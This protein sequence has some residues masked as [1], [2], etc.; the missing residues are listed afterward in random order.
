[1]IIVNNDAA[2]TK[3]IYLHLRGAIENIEEA[4]IGKNSYR[5]EKIGSIANVSYH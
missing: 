1:M 2:G 5:N 4:M 3:T